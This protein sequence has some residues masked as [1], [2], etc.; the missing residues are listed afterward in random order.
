M[1]RSTPPGSEGQSESSGFIYGIDG[2]RRGWVVARSRPDF[3]GLEIKLTSDLAPIFAEAGPRAIVVID[4]PIGIPENEPRVCDSVARR[5]LGWP[6][7]SSVFSPP[8]RRALSASTF[9]DALRLNRDAM[10]IGISKQAFNIANKIR[11]VDELMTSAR[12]RYVKEVHPEVTFTQLKG[13]P[14]KNSKK[15][16]NGRRERI[17]LLRRSGLAISE[18]YLV[19]R[20][21]QMGRACLSMDDVVDALGCLVMASFIRAGKSM[22]LGSMNQTDTKG[23]MMQIRAVQTADRC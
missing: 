12:Q 5:L 9:R 6:R 7:S 1:S 3:T 14:L 13:G 17:A 18:L 23:L 11:E 20:R 4:I 16:A 21:L 15:S 22:C 19:E 8:T 2:C 10:G